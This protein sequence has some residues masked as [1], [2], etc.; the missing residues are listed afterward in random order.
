MNSHDIVIVCCMDSDEKECDKECIYL[1]GLVT[2][3]YEIKSLI[4]RFPCSFSNNAYV[5]ECMYDR[6]K[7]VIKYL[8]T[9]FECIMRKI[10]KEKEKENEKSSNIRL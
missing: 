7:K 5:F 2:K 6:K 4:D 1:E 9:D 8:S 3:Y 10:I